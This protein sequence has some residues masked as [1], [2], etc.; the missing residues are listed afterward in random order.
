MRNAR[1]LR[2]RCRAISFFKKSCVAEGGR[3]SIVGSALS[4]DPDPARATIVRAL[5]GSPAQA[6]RPVRI[7]LLGYGRVGQ[8][9]AALAEVER[10]RLRGAGLDLRVVAALVRDRVKPRGGP[11]VVLHTD[12]AGLFSSRF[13]VLIDVMGGEHPAFEYVQRALEAGTH[14]VSANKT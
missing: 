8:A 14:V 5:H 2:H 3:V 9:V 10:D 6:A 4:A 12:A 7:G 11:S 1:A 13:D